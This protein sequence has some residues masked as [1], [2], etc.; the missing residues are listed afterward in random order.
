MYLYHSCNYQNNF[1]FFTKLHYLIPSIPTT[2]HMYTI[3][4][5]PF[6]FFL[7]FVSNQNE[8]IEKNRREYLF[9]ILVFLNSPELKL[10]PTHPT[11]DGGRRSHQPPTV[12]AA[13]RPLMLERSKLKTLKSE[14]QLAR[15]AQATTVHCCCTCRLPPAAV[16]TTKTTTVH[17]QRRY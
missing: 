12:A 4:G 7:I 14:S 10:N 11:H 13:Y 15:Q 16:H 2:S 8:T 1:I 9:S 6:P 17:S 5:D 3:Q